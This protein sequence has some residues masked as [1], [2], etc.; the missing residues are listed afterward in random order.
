MFTFR[1]LS[2]AMSEF[3]SKGA[4][5]IVVFVDDL[6]RCL[7]ENA[8]QV[9]ES[10]KLF[11]DIKGFVFVV[12]LDQRVIEQAVELRYQSIPRLV[13]PQTT[14]RAPRGAGA[15]ILPQAEELTSRTGEPRARSQTEEQA[16]LTGANYVKKIFQVQFSVP[17]IV[18]ADLEK[19]LDFLA[20][21]AKLPDPQRQNLTDVVRPHL[22]YLTGEGSVNPREVKRLINSYTLQ[23]KMLEKKLAPNP[24]NPNVVLSLQI[25]LFRHDWEPLYQF[26]ALEPDVFVEELKKALEEGRGELLLGAARGVPLPPPFATYVRRPAPGSALVDEP[27]EPYVSS[28]EAAVSTDT[29]IIEAM[30]KL[31]DLRRTLELSV[32][33][34]NRNELSR[35]VGQLREVLGRRSSD[36]LSSADANTRIFNLQGLFE[37]AETAPNWRQDVD[38]EM[39]TLEADLRELRRRSTVTARPTA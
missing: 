16:F 7:P 39:A 5:R 35:I 25:M 3:V 28:L 23:V 4:S 8:L 19:Y 22:S 26:L 27:L 2:Q 24:P 38:R 30:R 10:M 13:V 15:P 17:R 6:D 29:S 14:N 31:R 11:F 20:A 33:E 21:E 1:A 12:G 36:D 18:E 34:P 37:V 9:L 32:G